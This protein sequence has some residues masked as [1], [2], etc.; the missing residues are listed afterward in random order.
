MCIRDRD[1][2]FE[3]QQNIIQFLAEKESCIIV[4]RCSDFTLSE[5]ENVIHIYIYAPYEVRVQHCVCLLYTS[6][7]V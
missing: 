5:M 7:C 6:R 1:K 3:A 4:G 2:I